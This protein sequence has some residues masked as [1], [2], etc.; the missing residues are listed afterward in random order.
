[1]KKTIGLCLCLAAATACWGPQAKRYFEL[2]ARPGD[3]SGTAIDKAVFIEGV[4]VTDLYDDFRILYRLSPTEVNYYN[5]DFWTQKPSRLLRDAIYRYLIERN[6]FR[7]VLLLPSAEEPEWTLRAAVRRIE[8][9]DGPAGWSGRLSME[10]AVVE[11]KGGKIVARRSFDR[12]VPMPVKN[13]AALPP[14][15]SKILGEELE[16]LLRD[17]RAL[18][19]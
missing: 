4:T 6:A 1:M 8:E 7:R 13:A 10:L 2:D 16:L 11:S 3:A 14:A 12:A 5:Y 17:L 19:Q 15:L 9:L 18:G